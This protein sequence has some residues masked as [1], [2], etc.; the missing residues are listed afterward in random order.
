[1]GRTEARGLRNQGR[2]QELQTR[3]RSMCR[4]AT[5]AVRRARLA[6]I[7]SN[8][9]PWAPRG[10]AA[11]LPCPAVRRAM[12]W[13]DPS[14]GTGEA[15]RA[16]AEPRTALRLVRPRSLLHHP[17]RVLRLQ[18]LHPGGTRRR[19]PRRLDAGPAN[20]ARAGGRAAAGARAEQ[21]LRRRGNAITTG[22]SAR[23]RAPGHGARQLHGGNRR[24]DHHRG[25]PGVGLA[26]LF[27][28]DSDGRIHAG[29][30]G[31]AVGVAAGVGGAR[32]DP[33]A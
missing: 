17:L 21:R 33:H 8:S 5:R 24:R 25:K 29:V 16:G 14:R 27:R 32:Q 7:T 12:I 6:V 9:V 20:G 11:G 15:G 1:M 30:T 22:R 2:Q 28:G 10:S 19:Q 3:L 4:R 26:G 31:H 18:H 23:C 13:H